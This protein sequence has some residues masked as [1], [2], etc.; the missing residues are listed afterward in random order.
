M[1]RKRC[2]SVLVNCSGML[3]ATDALAG[4]EGQLQTITRALLMVIQTFIAP[5]CMEQLELFHVFY[6]VDY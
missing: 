3:C 5:K 2:I 1:S 6:N 4:Y